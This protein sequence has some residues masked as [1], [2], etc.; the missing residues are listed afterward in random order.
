MLVPEVMLLQPA[1]ALVLPNTYPGCQPS[2]APAHS[3]DPPPAVL[4]H[5]GPFNAF[6]EPADT[7]DHPLISLGLTGCPYMMMTYREED[8]AM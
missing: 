6:T 7:S 5:E 8:V 4:S 1:Q 2:H 3:V